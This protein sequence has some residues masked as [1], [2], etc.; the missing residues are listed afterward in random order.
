MLAKIPI[1]ERSETSHG[2]ILLE[3]DLRIPKNSGGLVVIAHGS[4]SGRLSSRNQSVAEKLNEDGLATLLFDL[5]TTSEEKVDTQTR[6]LRFDIRLLSKR[7]I[8]TLDWITKNPDTQNLNVGLFGASTGIAAA[9]VAAAERH[10]IVSAIVSR[11]GRPDLTCR[12][13]LERVKAPTLLLVGGNDKQVLRLNEEALKYIKAEKKK[14][15]VIP[16][17]SHLFEEPGKLEEVARLTSG[18]FRC[19]FLIKEHSLKQE[20]QNE[21]A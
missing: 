17:A 1:K 15:I 8:A 9:L 14:L 20:K 13:I 12:D 3:G 2:A 10:S 16:G 5:L 7:L 6:R 19:Y 18:W 11:G 4:G 21:A